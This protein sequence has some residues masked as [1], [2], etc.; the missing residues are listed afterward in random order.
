M[1]T[2]PTNL[3]FRASRNLRDAACGYAADLESGT[4]AEESAEDKLHQ[5]AL[6]YALVANA[7]DANR[8]TVSDAVDK[9]TKARI[10][11]ST[12]AASEGG[13]S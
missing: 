10:L 2:T 7:I 13:A 5:A 4:E 3:L 11:G 1:T 8:Y 9:A 6:D 12:A